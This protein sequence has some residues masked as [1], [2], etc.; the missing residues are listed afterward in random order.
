MFQTERE[1]VEISC[2]HY[3]KCKLLYKTWPRV[4]FHERP[5]PFM[6]LKIDLI[7]SW[8]RNQK[9]NSGP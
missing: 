1:I 4:K 7:D 8:D 5:A 6:L 9:F 3:I 2:C